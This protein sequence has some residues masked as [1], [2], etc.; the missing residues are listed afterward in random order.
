MRKLATIPLYVALALILVE[1][2]LWL[3]SLLVSSRLVPGVTGKEVVLCVGDSH[4]YGLGVEPHE[5]YPEQLQA[6][7]D[8][9]APDRYTVINAGIPE[10]TQAKPST[11][12]TS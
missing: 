6:V 12:S 9:I 3:G 8:S 4:T 2:I 1:G 10:R 7:L 11:G 5:A